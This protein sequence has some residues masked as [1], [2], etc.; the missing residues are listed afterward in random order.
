MKPFGAST[1]NKSHSNRKYGVADSTE[2]G[3]DSE[4]AIVQSE[5]RKMGQK[6]VGSGA[7]V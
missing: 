2:I 5:N 4:E 6:T 3:N 1:G 7:G